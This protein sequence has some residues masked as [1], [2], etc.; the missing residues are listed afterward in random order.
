MNISCIIPTSR[1]A[2]LLSCRWFGAYC[3][4]M[5]RGNSE[6]FERSSEKVNTNRLIWANNR[7]HKESVKLT[8][9]SYCAH[10]AKPASG[11]I[12][13]WKTTKKISKN[14][15]CDWGTTKFP[16]FS[17]QITEGAL[18]RAVTSRARNPLL[19][20]LSLCP[21]LR[22]FA[23][24]L[25]KWRI[26]GTH[27]ALWVRRFC[28]KE[29]LFRYKFDFCLF[30]SKRNGTDVLDQ[31]NG[32]FRLYKYGVVVWLRFFEIPNCRRDIA[33][34]W[35]CFFF[36]LFFNAYSIYEEIRNGKTSGKCLMTTGR[37]LKAG[38]IVSPGQWSEPPNWNT[39]ATQT[40]AQEQ[41]INVSSF[42]WRKF[43]DISSWQRIPNPE[44]V[45]TV[46]GPS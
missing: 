33:D 7:R 46:D 38:G 5:L 43:S 31:P 10:K 22:D 25:S 21:F 11:E 45:L 12:P 29:I 17:S 19:F 26:P 2:Y 23:L 37:R 4:C 42:F 18:G 9:K 8:R 39:K 27:A 36:F 14:K 35:T 13:R 44:G 20:F 15:V 28:M 40:R 32:I 41:S 24:F 3:G 30:H 1:H 34:F 16:C 6:K